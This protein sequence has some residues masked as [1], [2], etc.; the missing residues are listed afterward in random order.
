MGAIISVYG[1]AVCGA[2]GQEKNLFRLLCMSDSFRMNS[3]YELAGAVPEQA[4]ARLFVKVWVFTHG[5]ASVAATNTTSLPR[6]EI[7]EL[8]TEVYKELPNEA[9]IKKERTH[10]FSPS[11]QVSVM[12]V[13][14]GKVEIQALETAVKKACSRNEMLRSRILLEEDGH[15][16]YETGEEK[17][18]PYP[19]NGR[20][21]RL[22]R[23]D[24]KPGIHSF[25]TERWRAASVFRMVYGGGMPAP[26]NRSSSGRGRYVLCLSD[27]GHYD[28]AGGKRDPVPSLTAVSVPWTGSKRKAESASEVPDEEA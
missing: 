8:L 13:I 18:N 7:R 9:E 17:G 12:A 19:E 20:K 6:E 16:F 22:E 2:A 4:D 27:Q 3:I 26:Y 24:P 15:A 23:G 14:G 28:G 10:L 5:I 25:C 11:I 1:A 21:R